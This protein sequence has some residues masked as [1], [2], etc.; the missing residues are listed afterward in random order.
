MVESVCVRA[1]GSRKHYLALTA[2]QK[3]AFPSPPPSLSPSHAPSLCPHTCVI[4]SDA[5]Y[6]GEAAG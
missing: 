5:C 4:N 6:W 1:D 3:N 2:L